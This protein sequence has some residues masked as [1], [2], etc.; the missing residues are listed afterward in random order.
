MEYRGNLFSK[1][2]KAHHRAMGCPHRPYDEH[3][4]GFRIQ[5]RSKEV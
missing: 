2:G 3:G 5:Q 4:R 1:F